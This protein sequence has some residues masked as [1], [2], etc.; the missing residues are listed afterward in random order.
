LDALLHGT[1][2]NQEHHA[3]FA[4]IR[5]GAPTP[6]PFLSLTL[7]SLRETGLDIGLSELPGN[8]FGANSYDSKKAWSSLSIFSMQRNK[9]LKSR[10]GREIGDALYQ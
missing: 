3:L 5:I 4:A 10:R 1:A 9:I 6:S 8:G 7:S 2:I